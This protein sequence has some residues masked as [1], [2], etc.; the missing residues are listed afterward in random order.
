[1][2]GS[3]KYADVRLSWAARQRLEEERH[4]RAE[5]RRQWAEERHRQ[6]AAE[7][8]TM[9][10][11]R[12]EVAAERVK[13]LTRQVGELSGIDPGDRR[14]LLRRLADLDGRLPVS[15][16]ALGVD[17]ATAELMAV[18]QHLSAVLARVAD[19]VAGE[20]RV[21]AV[22]AVAASLDAEPDRLRLDGDGARRVDNL[23][24]TAR[25][26]VHDARR[27]RS[28]HAGLTERARQHL[29]NV[30]TRRNALAA[31]GEQATKALEAFDAVLA[32]AAEI[33]IELPGQD[34]AE[35][36]KERLLADLSAGLTTPAAHGAAALTRAVD[37]LESSL[38]E[39]LDK[40]YRTRL[41]VEAA[42]IALPRAGF[43]VLPETFTSTGSDASFQVARADG[44]V[45][46]VSVECIDGGVRL[47]YDGRAADFAVEQTAEGPAA[48]CDRTEELLERFHSELGVQDIEAGQLWWEGK[49]E[50]PDRRAEQMRP[51]RVA[52]PRQRG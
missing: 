8:A 3:P 38:E 33:G 14:E 31:V 27:F 35:A 13:E 2:S 30:A 46:G 1:M 9:I 12:R 5:E 7:R 26:V 48:V 6:R 11:R 52:Q 19:E 37:E 23:L 44:S 43:Q 42:A 15:S 50:R 29:E 20:N 49:P 25:E 32:E 39:W 24:R 28:V 45:M 40:I 18:E 16:D 34:R 17:T 51:Q 21:A 10:S 22:A 47:V 4:S 41:I 36:T